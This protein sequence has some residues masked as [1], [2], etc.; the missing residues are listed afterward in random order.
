[1][2]DALD[3]DVHQRVA[4]TVLDAAIRSGVAHPERAPA[5]L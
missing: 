3:P 1:V 4:E 5:G 2:P